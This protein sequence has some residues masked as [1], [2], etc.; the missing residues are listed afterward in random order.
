MREEE[1]LS[2]GLA[3]SASYRTGRSNC[4]FKLLA[5]PVFRLR[6]LWLQDCESHLLAGDVNLPGRSVTL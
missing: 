1:S 2:S 5:A 4:S 3:Q 6:F